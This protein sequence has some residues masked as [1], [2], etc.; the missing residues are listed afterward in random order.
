MQKFNVTFSIASSTLDFISCNMSIKLI[1]AF[2]L[3]HKTHSFNYNKNDPGE[4]QM[5]MENQKYLNRKK[6]I[7]SS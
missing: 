4:R 5:M 1:L 3:H 7:S 2:Y 6:C